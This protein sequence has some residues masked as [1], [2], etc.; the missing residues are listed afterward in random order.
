MMNDGQLQPIEQTSQS[1]QGSA[2]LEFRDLS[3]EKKY[4]WTETVPVKFK[5][6]RPK[7][8][9]VQIQDYLDTMTEGIYAV[10]NVL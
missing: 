5:Y 4:K 8:A 7:I 2:A 1:P 6:N 9:E 10:D 3:A